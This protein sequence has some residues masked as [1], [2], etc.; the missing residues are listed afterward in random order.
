M[1]L[2]LAAS[3]FARPATAAG[4]TACARAGSG[5]TTLVADG[6]L[7]VAVR[8]GQKRYLFGW[9][10]RPV[11]GFPEALH[12][13]RA[14]GFTGT[15]AQLLR[16]LEGSGIPGATFADAGS[17]SNFTLGCRG[18][19][20]ATALVRSDRGAITATRFWL[21]EGEPPHITRAFCMPEQW[22]PTGARVSVTFHVP[23]AAAAPV[24][25]IDWDGNGQVDS[26]GPFRRGG[27]RFPTSDR[28]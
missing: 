8:S 26:L 1:A 10:D 12:L 15:D 21:Q 19:Y 18:T 7:Y 28:C 13:I 22:V 2:A 16:R 11:L 9:S 6:N 24:F 27:T 3:L 25:T 4:T 14:L 23:L 5:P 20:T 17:I